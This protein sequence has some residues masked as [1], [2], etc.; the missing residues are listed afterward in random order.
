M[1]RK[2]AWK[3][4]ALTAATIGGLVFAVSV[5]PADSTGHRIGHI[6]CPPGS[7]ASDSRIA[8]GA[9]LMRAR[10][11]ALQARSITAGFPSRTDGR[12]DQPNA[13]K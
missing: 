2:A 8:F 5:Q 12:S 3:M 9:K 6:N 1:Q 10:E 7:H 4:A 11:Q 13:P